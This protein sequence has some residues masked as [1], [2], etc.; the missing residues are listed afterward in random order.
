MDCIDDLSGKTHK[1]ELSLQNGH[2]QERGRA[3]PN[4]DAASGLG[5]GATEDHLIHFVQSYPLGRAGQPAELASIYVQLAAN[6]ASYTTG[7]IYGAGGG[8]GQ[9]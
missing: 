1:R 6:D 9:S 3:G 2:P 8:A 5:G 7:N 4:L